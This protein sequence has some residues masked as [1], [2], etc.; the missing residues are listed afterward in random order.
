MDERIGTAQARELGDE[1]R[2]YRE[3]MGL[4]CQVLADRLGWSVSK[5]SRIENALTGITEL[6]VVRYAAHCGVDAGSIDALLDMCREPGASGYWL[7]KRLST[8]LFHENTAAS[9][10]SYD[11]LVVPGL[12]QTEEYATALIGD[13]RPWLVSARMERQRV[14]HSRKFEFFIHEQALRLPVGDNRV[15]NEQLLKLVLV[16]E[17][18]KIRIRVVPASLG[19]RSMLGGS[20]VLFRYDAY[21]PLVY[22]EHQFLGFF[23][24]DQD[25][26]AT[27][28]ENL[29][30]LSDVALGR[31]ES[32]EGLAALASEFDQPEVPR[33][34]PDPLAEE[35]L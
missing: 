17:L 16:A 25:Y 4:S 32:R 13:D 30:R 19:A 12:L 29:T 2:Q 8:L 5:V 11:P 23:V 9:S 15:M 20:F 3:A 34:V 6:D 33:D 24:E 18:P 21:R 7:T 14:L 1:L 22:L 31:G 10:A 28:R 35:Q 26:V 27:Y